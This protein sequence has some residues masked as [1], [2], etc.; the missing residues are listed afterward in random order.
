M[1][2]RISLSSLPRASLAVVAPFAAK[3]WKL[4]R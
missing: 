2:H 4:A 1:Q 3:F